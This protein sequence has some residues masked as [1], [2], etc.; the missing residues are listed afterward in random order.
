MKNVWGGYFDE[1]NRGLKISWHYPFQDFFKSYHVPLLMK[2]K[3][4]EMCNVKGNI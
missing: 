3:R 1:K 4:S 2:I